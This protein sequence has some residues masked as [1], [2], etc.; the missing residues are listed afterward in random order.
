ME[1]LTSGQKKYVLETVVTKMILL[2]VEETINVFLNTPCN[3]HFQLEHVSNI[4]C[5]VP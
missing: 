1:D 5:P 3:Y 2:S 4:S